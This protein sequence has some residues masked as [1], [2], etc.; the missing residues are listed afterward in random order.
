MPQAKNR[1]CTAIFGK[2]RCRNC[3]ATFAFLQSG[4]RFAKSCAATNEKLHCNIKK[5]ALQ[6]SGAFL[7]LSCGF[8]APTFRLPRLG[9]ADS[10]NRNNFARLLVCLFYKVFWRVLKDD[11]RNRNSEA[12][13]KPQ[14]R[15]PVREEKSIHHHRGDPP[16]FL[17]LGLRLYGVY[18]SFRT[19]GVYPFPLFSQ[20]NGIHHS[21]FCTVTSGSGDRPRKEGSRGGGVYSSFF[22][23]L[24]GPEQG[25]NERNGGT[26]N[27]NEDTKKMERRSKKPDRGCI[28][29]NRPFTKPPFI[30]SRTLA[31]SLF[32]LLWTF[33]P[34]TLSIRRQMMEAF[35]DP[36]E[37]Y[38]GK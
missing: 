16:F 7:P 29:Q 28:C 2:L 12:K 38:P 27:P 17:F 26:K 6:E 10:K 11:L 22:F 34:S 35:C 25:H 14:R 36:A 30:S 20:E 9:P 8:Q 31:L 23:S 4:S 21:F 3:I 37:N 24:A 18:P 19:Y 15:T 1:G 33:I 32:F 13:K 5:A